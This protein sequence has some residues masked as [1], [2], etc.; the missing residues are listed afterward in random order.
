MTDFYFYFIFP[1][2]QFSFSTSRPNI[3]GPPLNRPQPP[4]LSLPRFPQSVLFHFKQPL[5][6]ILEN[7]RTDSRVVGDLKIACCSTKKT[8]KKEKKLSEESKR[9]ERD[10]PIRLPLAQKDVNKNVFIEQVLN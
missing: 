5:Q 1:A 4:N 7:L 9:L 3:S 10:L 6:T 8:K 2:V